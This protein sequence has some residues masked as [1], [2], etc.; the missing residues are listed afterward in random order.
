MW[1]V[2]LGLSPRE[3]DGSVQPILAPG[4][5]PQVQTSYREWSGI[6]LLGGRQPFNRFRVIGKSVLLLRWVNWE[7]PRTWGQLLSK[8]AKGTQTPHSAFGFEF[9]SS[10]FWFRCI[11]RICALPMYSGRRED[12]RQQRTGMGQVPSWELL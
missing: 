2:A 7:Q 8:V 4:I 9:L 3:P 5:N 1:V 12:I 11:R 10:V 6:V